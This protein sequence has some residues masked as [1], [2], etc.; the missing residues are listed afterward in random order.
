MYSV[1][2]CGG[3]GTRLWPLSRKNYPK[4]FL[5]LFG[6]KS[7]LQET[8]LRTQ[9]IFD[10]EK[11]FCVTNK[12]NYYNVLNQIREINP[13]FNE[14]NI[15]CEPASMN[16]LPA[17]AL[18]VK[19]LEDKGI[20]KNTPIAFFP[21]DH[22]ITDQKK[23]SETVKTVLREVANHVATIGVTPTEPH[24]GYGY[25]KKGNSQQSF[26]QVS[27]FKEKP[28]IK[29]AKD[30]MAS[31]NY[32]WNAGM[33]VFTPETFAAELK[34]HAPELSHAFEK[35]LADMTKEFSSLP[36]VSV[37]TG[38]SEK[39]KR[40]IVF[41]G[42]FGWNDIGSFDNLVNL[43]GV[44]GSSRHV[45]IGSENVMVLSAGKKLIA[46]L[47]LED[48]VIVEAGDSILAYRR[49]EGEKVKD[50]LTHLKE[51]N[52]PEVEHNLIAHRPWGFYEI[53]IDT[54]T[55]KVKKIT[56]YPH[57]WLSLQSHEH[58]NEHWVVVK[59]KA[60][61]IVDEN[62]LTLKEY[63]SAFIAKHTKHRLEN[64]YDT[65]LEVIEVQTGD[66]LGEDDIVRYE[67]KYKR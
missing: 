64:P 10:P 19:Y 62:I 4:Q 3:S 36:A 18:S 2:L 58:R 42:S 6:D 12:D 27:E 16:T 20:S 48:V 13:K 15:I 22:Y 61:A 46:T 55:Y 14:E 53:L 7:L 28:D 5:K 17:M 21:A 33:Y 35:S 65:L 47:G 41:E 54:P 9:D 50:I 29:T 38:L 32:L 59:G 8:Y 39:S 52:Y 24:T 1:I 11:I 26:F 66:Y 31:G 23:F 49:G 67:D 63:E 34:I 44:N 45:S 60:R 51:N 40:V 57:E 37:D 43:P 30:Y 25:I 56:V